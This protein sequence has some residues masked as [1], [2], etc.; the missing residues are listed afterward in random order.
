MERYL[1]IITDS[2]TDYGPEHTETNKQRALE[3]A[4]EHKGGLYQRS[5]GSIKVADL[6]EHLVIWHWTEGAE[7]GYFQA[8]PTHPYTDM[9]IGAKRWD[10]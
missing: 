10:S 8:T 4:R 1:I 7:G 9:T 2:A 3:V 5:G 6:Q